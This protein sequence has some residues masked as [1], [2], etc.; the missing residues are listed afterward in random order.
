M[1]PEELIEEGRRFARPI[2]LLTNEGNEYSGIWRGDG[3]VAPTNKSLKHWLTI[4]LSRVPDAGLKGCLSVYSDGND[5]GECAHDPIARLPVSPTGVM[6]H[7]R[8]S[9]C[10]PPIEEL[11]RRGSPRVQEWLNSKPW[12]PEWGYN[13]NFPDADGNAD[14]YE[15]AYQASQPLYGELSAWVSLGGWPMQWPEDD[16]TPEQSR[17]AQLIAW[18]YRDAEPWLEI[19][20]SNGAFS[21]EHRV[22]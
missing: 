17:G 2:T 21:I 10:L 9:K 5:I 11:F 1:T 14:A 20:L 4:D 13:S 15:R 19:W 7:A 22:T 16:A 12:N 18:T 3:V 8:E 6:L